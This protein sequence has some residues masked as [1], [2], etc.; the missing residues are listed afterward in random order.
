MARRSTGFWGFVALLVLAHFLV[1]IALG[2][3]DFVPDLLTIAALLAARRL[4]SPV[5]TLLG[6]VLGLLEDALALTAFGA[7]AVATAAV[8]FLGAQSRD[9][10]EGDSI[11][12]LAVYLFIGKWA[13]EA[14]VYLLDMRAA[15]GD[16]TAV[17]LVDA[18]LAALF[19]AVAGTIAFL[20]YRAVSGER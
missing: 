9:L 8:S 17:L 10:F 19:A 11:I 16:A 14:I 1:R 3:N 18:P 15:R 20:L 13:R 6:L 7:R 5:A 2:L 4:R 12:F